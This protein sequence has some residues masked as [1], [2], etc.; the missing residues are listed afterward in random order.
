MKLQQFVTQEYLPHARGNLKPR[1][2]SEYE[3]L[4]SRLVLPAFG[5]KQLS[6]LSR[7]Q[8]ERWHTKLRQ[9]APVQANRALATLASVLRLAVRWDYIPANPAHGVSP[10]KEKARE[11][12][13]SPEETQR[14]AAALD[15]LTAAERVFV[16]LA[17]Y[18]GARPGELLSARWG[19][20]RDSTLELPDSKTGRRTVYLSDPAV[21]ALAELPAGPGEALIFPALD[22]TLVWRRVRRRSGLDCRLYDLR[23]S[24]ASAGLSAGLSLE[25]IGQLLGHRQAQTT[26]RYAHLTPETGIESAA[27]AAAVL[28]KMAGA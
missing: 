7:A 9:G 11:R 4:L 3:R 1:T 10:A 21:A 18:T 12:Y 19:W 6:A 25:N 8:I 26:K 28:S 24:F 16:K 5:S 20:L 17:L 22:P 23:H 14:L 15:L 27:R 13:L 2:V